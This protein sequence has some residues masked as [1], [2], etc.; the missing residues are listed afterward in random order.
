M[1]EWL[2]RT[3]VEHREALDAGEYSSVELT[4]AFLKRIEE[5]EGTVGAFLTVDAE[6]ALLAAAESDKR[7]AKGEGRGL[8][9]G[10]PY[11]IKDNFCTKGIRTTC[12]SRMLED[13]VPPYDATVVERLREAGCVLLGKLNLDEFAMGSTNETSALGVT[14]NP[15]DPRYVAGGSSGGSA[16]AVA[17]NEAVF[18]IGSDTGGSVR[19]PAAFCGVLGLKPTYCAI[20]RYGLIPMASSLD[21]V[22]ILTRSAADTEIVFSA[23]CGKDERD[24]TVLVAPKS[25]AALKPI[26][27]LRVAVVRELLDDAVISKEMGASLRSAMDLLTRNGARIEEVSLPAPAQALAA[28]CVISAAEAASNMARF[29]GIRFGKRIEEAE[30]LFSLYANTRGEFLGDEVKRRILFGTSMLSAQNRARY[31]DSAIS[32]REQIRRRL[33][34][35]FEDF[36]LILT[37][38]TPTGAFLRGEVRSQAQR[39]RADLCAVYSS[40]AGLPA[41]SV[42]FGKTQN[43]LPLAVQLTAAPFAEKTIFRVAELLE[44]QG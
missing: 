28:Y 32:M 22:G 23:L 3:I 10:I 18:T 43:G 20:S 16:A 34:K 37:P 15:H 1:T 27:E 35:L 2:S 39:R 25:D 38:T 29:D 6:G 11:A 4:R 8:L 36:D 12:A 19:Q 30:D 33:L 24:H 42:P 5:K 44:A 17:A 41:L 7:R 13:F 14:R 31:Y 9:E 21:C 26:S 40:L